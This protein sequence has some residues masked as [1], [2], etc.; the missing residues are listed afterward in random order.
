MHV[1]PN[2]GKLRTFLRG[3]T[4][5]RVP[6]KEEIL[7]IIISSVPMSNQSV[8]EIN[9]KKVHSLHRIQK[10]KVQYTAHETAQNTE[11]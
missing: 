1:T 3:V 8:H 10:S 9:L 11:I 7:S 2:K 5:V 4:N 6:S